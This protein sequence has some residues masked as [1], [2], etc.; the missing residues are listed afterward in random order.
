M[1]EVDLVTTT[2]AGQHVALEESNCMREVAL[3]TATRAGQHVALEES[4][5][6]PWSPE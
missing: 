3:V 6:G 4:N 5:F 1:R 2:R